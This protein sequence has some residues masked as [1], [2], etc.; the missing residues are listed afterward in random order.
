MVCWLRACSAWNARTRWITCCM[1]S[2]GGTGSAR[3][4]SV[5]GWRTWM[6]WE[7]TPC[8]KM[9]WHDTDRELVSISLW[10]RVISDGLGRPR[11]LLGDHPWV[12]Y[13]WTRNDWIV[14]QI[15][16]S[17]RKHNKPSSYTGNPGMGSSIWVGQRVISGWSSIWS[18]CWTH[19]SIYR[20]VVRGTRWLVLAKWVMILSLRTACSHVL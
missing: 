10:I 7:P 17:H 9:R 15:C 13:Q 11:W 19:C 5:S 14:R 1:A 3:C 16:L 2:T 6:K 8:L 20:A 4:E 12:C 18:H